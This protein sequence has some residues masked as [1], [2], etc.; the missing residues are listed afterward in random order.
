MAGTIRKAIHEGDRQLR[1]T[2]VRFG[3]E[4]RLARL[5]HGVTQ[6]S[7]A[8]AIGVHR[9]VICRLEAGNAAISGRVRARAV[10]VLGGDFRIAVYPSGTPLIHDAAHARL[11]EALLRLRSASWRAKVE[12]PVP[13]PGRQSTDIRLDR[14]ADTVLFEVETRVHALEA[15]VR[16]GEGKRTA[17][18]AGERP[19]RRVH[20]VLVLPPTRHHRA[21]VAA[22][23]ET[24]KA[25]FPCRS[26]DLRRAL[27][28]TDGPWPGDGILWLG[29]GVESSVGASKP[30]GSLT[31]SHE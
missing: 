6:A 29:A 9:S 2:A 23:P 21:L 7:V 4:F 31:G 24:I 13:G 30:V 19:G 28:S 22:H 16:E 11:V 15:I 20:L 3:E 18:A 12:A 17:V 25:A 1:R 27:V 26:A 5:R 10:A 8:R 14:A